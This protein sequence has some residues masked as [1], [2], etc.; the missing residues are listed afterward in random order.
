MGTLRHGCSPVNLLHIFRTPFPR[1]TCGWLL[2]QYAEKPIVLSIFLQKKIMVNCVKSFFKISQNHV[3]H[4]TLAKT[5]QTVKCI[6][7]SSGLG[8]YVLAHEK[9]FL[10]LWILEVTKILVYGYKSD[11]KNHYS[12]LSLATLQESGNFSEVIESLHK[13]LICLDKSSVSSFRKR[14][15]KL[16]SRSAAFE[17]QLLLKQLELS[18]RKQMPN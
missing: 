1:N 15:N 6:K 17:T 7:S 18:F 4:H 14:Q 10:Q 11:L 16:Y 9:P 12:G 13:S 8:N 2:L 5:N 3:S